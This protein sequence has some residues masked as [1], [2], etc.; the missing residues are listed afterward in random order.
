MSEWNYVI[1][2]YALTWAVLVGYAVYL[3]G[4]DRRALA[5]LDD[6]SHTEERL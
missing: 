2:A 3:R 6:V 4:R 5:M 1:G